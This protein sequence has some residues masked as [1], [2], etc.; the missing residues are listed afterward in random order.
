MS[1]WIPTK[2]SFENEDNFDVETI[3]FDVPHFSAS[4]GETFLFVKGL[5]GGGA[6]GITINRHTAG[7]LALD[8]LNFSMEREIEDDRK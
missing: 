2:N 5:S 4:G 1:N 7:L 3:K 6:E 8:L